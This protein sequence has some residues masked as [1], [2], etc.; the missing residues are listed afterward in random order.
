LAISQAIHK[1]AQHVGTIDPAH[2]KG[3]LFWYRLDPSVLKELEQQFAAS[4]ADKTLRHAGDVLFGM[5]Q[6][7]TG[8]KPSYLDRL[9]TYVSESARCGYSPATAVYAQIMHAHGKEPE[10]DDQTLDRWLLQAVAEGYLFPKPSPRVSDEHLE[11]ARQK[12]RDSGGFCTD[13]F[14]RK[15]DIMDIARDQLKVVEWQMSNRKVVDNYG[16]TILHVA[17]A[18][19][20]ID[21]V[22]WLVEKAHVPVDVPNDNSESPLYKACQAGQGKVIHYLLDKGANASTPTRQAGLTALHWL[23]TIPEPFLRELATRLVREA[24]ASVNAMMV[25]EMGG[26]GGPYPQRLSMAHLYVSFLVI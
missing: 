7:I 21:V 13:P 17:A 14:T 9:L 8:A 1:N 24:G 11:M 2:N 12:F 6:N 23:F 20:A 3:P 10:Y 22:R 26:N 18:L 15:P 5:A 25:P 4:K 19:G 16:N